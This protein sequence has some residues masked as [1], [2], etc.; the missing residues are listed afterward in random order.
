MTP[1]AIRAI[2]LACLSSCLAV[3]LWPPVG[4]LTFAA[5]VPVAVTLAFGIRPGTRW[6]GGVATLMIPYLAVAVMNILAG[7]MARPPAIALGIASALAFVAG[8]AWTRRIG[9][10]LRG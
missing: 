9:A 10:T 6:G 5:A 2:A 8:L 7:P 3:L 4:A 1:D